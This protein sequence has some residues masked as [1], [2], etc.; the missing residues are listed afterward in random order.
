VTDDIPNSAGE[1]LRPGCGCLLLI[2]ISSA[3]SFITLWG[4][5]EL[6]RAIARWCLR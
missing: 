4:V 1:T 6:A 2:F 5:F 3:V